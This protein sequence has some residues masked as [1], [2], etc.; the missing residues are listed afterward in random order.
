MPVNA[1]VA[2][3]VAIIVLYLEWQYTLLHFKENVSYSSCTDR[4]PCRLNPDLLLWL[5]WASS[6]GDT[7]CP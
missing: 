2:V 6:P 5:S 7:L 1:N 3:S 4:C